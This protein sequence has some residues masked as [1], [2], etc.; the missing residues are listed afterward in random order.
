MKLNLCG[1]WQVYS[2]SGQ[3][4]TGTVPGCVH[5]DLYPSEWMFWEKNDE[6]CRW[7][8]EQDWRY[9]KR[10]VI[11]KLSGHPV[12]VFEGLD[13]YCDIYLN[14]VKVGSAD[15]MFIPHRFSVEG[16]L[17]EGRNILEV[18]FRS[19]VREVEGLEMLPGAFTTERLHTR[20]LQCTYGWDWVSRFV[21]CGIYRPAYIELEG[22]ME[23]EDVYIF[24]KEIDAYSAQIKVTEHFKY[25]E[26]G[27]IVKT[28]VLDPAGEVAAVSEYYCEE[29]EGV[30]YFDIPEPQLWYPRPYGAQPLYTL[31]IT[32]GEQV[33]EERFGIRMVKILQLPDRDEE[34]LQKCRALQATVSGQEYDQNETYSGFILLINGVRIFC[35]GANWV[36]CEPFPSAEE[37]GKITE[38]LTK[39]ATGGINMIRVWGG[40][41]FEKQHF[42]RE[43][44]RLGLLV[45]Q[46]FLMACGQ[47]PEEDAHFREQ[48]RREAEF[49]AIYLR[50][51]PCLVWWTGDNENAVNGHDTMEHYQGRISARKVIAPVLEKLDYNRVF[52]FS[53][54][55]GGKKYASKT[56]GTTH[57]TQFLGSTLQYINGEDVSDYKEYFKD[58]TARFIAEEPMMGAASAASM[59]RFLDEGNLQKEELWLHHTKT[60]PA[61]GKELY[62]II[63]EF[64]RKLLG[65][66]TDWEDRCFKLRYLQYEWV[67]L[68]LGN[69]RS[70][71]WFNS[72]IVYW[73]LNDCWPAAIGWSLLDYYAEPKGGYYAIKSFD[74]PVTAHIEKVSGEKPGCGDCEKEH[75]G[76]AG[77]GGSYLLHLSTIGPAPQKCKARLLLLKP[78]ENKVLTIFEQEL[79]V[80]ETVTITFEQIPEDPELL[81]VAEVEPVLQA[82]GVGKPEGQTSDDAVSMYRHRAW[83]RA[84]APYLVAAEG[85]RYTLQNQELTVTADRYVHAVEIEAEGVLADNYFSLLPGETRKVEL[86]ADMKKI[87][88]RG[89]TF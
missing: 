13:T 66:F 33:T 17:Q 35:T 83:Y 42:Y 67:R 71:L 56:V 44:D 85:L 28:E 11:E 14:H 63:V 57:N 60:N 7:I 75:H 2:G 19:P 53:S 59:A 10:F 36:P 80:R 82:A 55:Y 6:K 20:R 27:S 52:L 39:A 50:N 26:Q 18:A 79:T 32:V 49:A 23:L 34:A 15:N 16:I 43:C 65:E 4:H 61:L 9:E 47:Y 24:T 31:R 30:L 48:L 74:K 46:D 12:L 37:E 73:M 68:T 64:A 3:V 54:P 89:Y 84:G 81:L 1:E 88:V 72:G 76:E 22:S 78:S 87:V 25:Y 8:E 38:L 86:T 62:D 51:H 45:T 77:T 29:E 58:F 69:A 41:L 70:N 40:G 21:T 5:T